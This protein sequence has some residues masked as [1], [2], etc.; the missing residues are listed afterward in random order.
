MEIYIVTYNK[1]DYICQF[2]LL[3]YGDLQV[4]TKESLIRFNKQT[5]EYYSFSFIGGKFKKFKFKIDGEVYKVAEEKAYM[6]AMAVQSPVPVSEAL[7]LLE[8]QIKVQS[9]WAVVNVSVRY[10]NRDNKYSNLNITKSM[11]ANYFK[12]I[13][14]TAYRRISVLKLEYARVFVA[15]YVEDLKNQLLH[16]DKCKWNIEYT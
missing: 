13:N 4:Y 16:G 3:S 6:E 15:K 12:S 5:K 14:D 2:N 9:K 8:P 1:Y 11:A 7:R 10:L